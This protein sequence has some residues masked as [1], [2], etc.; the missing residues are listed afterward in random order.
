VQALNP[1][2]TGVRFLRIY[3]IQQEIHRA[4]SCEGALNQRGLDHACEEGT[5]RMQA[6]A[7]DD[8]KGDH[9][10]NTTII[11]WSLGVVLIHPPLQL[12][13]RIDTILIRHA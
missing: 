12:Q 3:L 11:D 6:I 9:Y 13:S 7:Q 5:S 8:A 2:E 4:E 1:S 10:P